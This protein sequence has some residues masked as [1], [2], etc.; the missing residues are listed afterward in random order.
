M[1][2]RETNG[3]TPK[4]SFR[5]PPG[6]LTVL[7]LVSLLFVGFERVNLG[8]AMGFDLSVEH[9]TAQQLFPNKKG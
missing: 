3:P 8:H 4:H 9:E 7:R 5:S 6:E 2:S 1:L